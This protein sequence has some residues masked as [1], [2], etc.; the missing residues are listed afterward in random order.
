MS[1]VIDLTVTETEV[2][3]NLMRAKIEALATKLI[4]GDTSGAQ[5]TVH[6]TEV[7]RNA[8]A[9]GRED[10]AAIA[11]DAL[12]STASA[13]AKDLRTILPAFIERMQQ[14]LDARNPVTLDETKKNPTG[15]NQGAALFSLGEDAEMIS[16]FILES[17][18]HLGVVETRMMELEKD[19]EDSDSINAAFRGFHT[20]KGLAGFFDLADIRDVAHET[21]TLLDL[22]R[23]Q[24]LRFTPSVVDVVLAAADVLK[25]LLKNVENAIAGLEQ[26]SVPELHSVLARIRSVTTGNDEAVNDEPFQEEIPLKEDKTGEQVGGTI[27]VK[28]GSARSDVVKNEQ[29]RNEPSRKNAT[30][31]T[32]QV[33]VNTDKLDYLVDMAGEM[34]IA[35]SMVRHHPELVELHSPGL[36]RSLS[37]LDRIT[38]ELQKTAMS[39]RMVPIGGLFQKMTRLVRDLARKTGKQAEMEEIGGETE[40]DRNVVEELADPLMHMIRNAADH[41]IESIEERRATGKNP[42]GRIR[43]R[44]SH[45][46]GYIVIEVSDDGRGLSKEKILAKAKRIHLIEEGANPS[47]REIFNLIFHPGFSTAA[48]ITDVSGRGVGMD[49]VLKQIQKLRGRVDIESSPGQGTK[50]LLRLPLTLAMIDGLVV[51]VGDERYIVPLHSVREM[52]RPNMEMMFTVENRQEMALVRESLLPVVRLHQRFNVAPRSEQIEDGLLVV[53][54]ANGKNFCLLVDDL[55]GKQEVVIK[56]LGETLTN[57]AGIAGGAILG[58]GRIGLILDLEGILSMGGTRDQNA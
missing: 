12:Q 42:I 29:A 53:A 39:M 19:P 18:D 56:S 28:D 50:F 5:W 7:I 34:I 32:R 46:A 26:A 9:N 36:L 54:E 31:A 35:Q 15:G 10:L 58:D 57:I 40:L 21:E 30:V 43:L 51:G 33:K 13:K 14:C 45:Q 16:E 38:G 23:N 27:K 48:Q 20:I 8:Q 49:V 22:A 2:S 55:I 11:S 24:K 37:Q 1:S 4:L 47:E 3:E 44:A 17:R 25:V 41:G 6:F 52:L